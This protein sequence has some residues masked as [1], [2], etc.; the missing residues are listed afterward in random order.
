MKPADYAAAVRRETAA[1]AEA[2]AGNLERAVPGCPG[3]D[4]RGLVHHLGGVQRFWRQVVEKRLE[5]PG[6]ALIENP[7]TD[8]AEL[9][10]WLREGGE[11]LAEVLEATDPVTPVWTWAPDRTVRFIQRKQAVEAALH[12]WD[13]ED[14]AGDAHPIERELALAGLGEFFDVLVP[15]QERP[16]LTQ[17]DVILFSP[18]DSRLGWRVRGGDGRPVVQPDDRRDDRGEDDAV[19]RAPASDLLLVLWRRLDP[20]SVE[21]EDGKDVLRRFL[22]A[23]D[24]D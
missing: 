4:V 21:I 22:A 8:H 20:T 7:P 17:M 24:L 10:A 15:L 1:L 19:A 6:S 3:W 11:R 18:T 12:R 5:D 9:P 2:C 13:G 16:L 14:A 23:L